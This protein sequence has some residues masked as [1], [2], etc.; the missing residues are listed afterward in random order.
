MLG[1]GRI[2]LILH[3]EHD[4]DVFLVVVIVAEY[5]VAFGSFDGLVVLVEI[6]KRQYGTEGIVV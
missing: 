6:G 4:G 2:H 5:K 1:G 3:L